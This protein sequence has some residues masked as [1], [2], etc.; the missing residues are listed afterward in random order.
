MW[1]FLPER[2]SFYE[3][4]ILIQLHRVQSCNWLNLLFHS[5]SVE[6]EYTVQLRIVVGLR[7]MAVVRYFYDS[8]LLSSIKFRKQYYKNHCL[9]LQHRSH[10]LAIIFL[11][12]QK[13]RLILGSISWCCLSIPHC[14]FLAV[15]C[16]R[17]DKGVIPEY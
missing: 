6:T 13:C 14:S 3:Y 16:L 2:V 11:I 10:L 12:Y 7:Q 5:H 4:F 9:E 17:S 1:D 8:F 15:Q